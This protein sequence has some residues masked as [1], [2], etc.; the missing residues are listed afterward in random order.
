MLG[1]MEAI[2]PREFASRQG[3]DLGLVE[4]SARLEQSAR[5]SQSNTPR[6]S[7]NNKKRAQAQGIWRPRGGGLCQGRPEGPQGQQARS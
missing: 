3:P 1:D 2:G 6:T 4:L 7:C 5:G